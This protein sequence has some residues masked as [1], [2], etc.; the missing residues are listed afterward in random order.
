MKKYILF[1][2]LLLTLLLAACN[3]SQS[4][5]GNQSGKPAMVTPSGSPQAA[6]DHSLDPM[7]Q[8]VENNPSVEGYLNLGNA[9]TE[10][11]RFAEAV[12][13]YKKGLAINPNHPA[14]L[15]NLGVALYQLGRY[16]EAQEQFKKAL[17][18]NPN[19]AATT[20]LLGATYLQTGDQ[21]NAELMFKKALAIEPTLPEA[22][23]G[24]GALYALQGKKDQAIEEFET[25]L[26]GPPAQD[27]R[28]KSEA[29]R[30]LKQLKSGQ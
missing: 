25:F 28:A 23:F 15:A 24:L 6:V 26:A 22:H 9:Y 2:L 12:D 4:Q 7:K 14:T 18:V 8:E 20:Y 30:Y 5:N 3:G 1:P 11:A 21:K 10:R 29:E 13:A 17:K 27:P 16:S 19:D